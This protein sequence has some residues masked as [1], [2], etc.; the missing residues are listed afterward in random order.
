[1]PLTAVYYLYTIIL[2]SLNLSNCNFLATNFLMWLMVAWEE[3]RMNFFRSGPSLL[4]ESSRTILTCS[5]FRC[6]SSSPSLVMS[7]CRSS[8][9]V[10]RWKGEWWFEEIRCWVA[11]CW[12]VDQDMALCNKQYARKKVHH[13]VIAL[14]FSLYMNMFLNAFFLYDC[15]FDVN[16][17]F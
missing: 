13:S 11:H 17:H 8:V 15:M 5:S 12:Q 14:C 9:R 7:F 4:V 3:I 16:S 6:W 2:T 1:M 10:R